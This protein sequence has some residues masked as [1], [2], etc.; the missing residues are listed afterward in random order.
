MAG[1]A[2]NVFTLPTLPLVIGLDV[3]GTNTD[4]VLLR[5]S[6]L[7]ASAKVPSSVNGVEE[8]V[9]ALAGD[10]EKVR[11]VFF[12]T[13]AFVNALLE[14]RGLEKVA[15]VRL[16]GPSSRSLPPFVDFVTKRYSVGRNMVR[17]GRTLLRWFRPVP[18]G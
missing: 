6:S 7:I 4:S 13:K 2:K 10:L 11:A 15:A 14:G 5:G 12:G 16:C 8:A 1:T 18:F 9:C 17:L 3:G